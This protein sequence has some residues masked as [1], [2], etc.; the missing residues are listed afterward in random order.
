MFE[1]QRQGTLGHAKP[2]HALLTEAGG[3]EVH[4]R[5]IQRHWKRMGFGWLRTKNR[6]RSLREQA[7]VRQHRHDDLYA[8]RRTRHRPPDER[9]QVIY[10]AESFLP[11]HHGGP[12]AWC[13]DN[14]FV[15][16]RSGK[17]RRWGFMHAMQKTGVLTGTFLAFEAQHGNGDDHAQ[18]DGAMFQHWFTAQFLR[19]V[20]PHSLMILD[21]CPCHTGGRD[22]VVPSQ[23]KKGAL[24][25]WLT[26]RGVAWEEQWL[27]ARRLAERDRERE[28]KPMVAILAAAQGHK[29]LFLPGHHPE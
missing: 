29:V 12:Y 7:E 26:E 20:P 13:S 14:D 11:H 2:V 27:R 4:E 15:E 17:G 23:M 16:R 10:V 8:L 28:K 6:P 22:A 5:T 3:L 9:Y 21:R 25:P 19:H 1:K 18:G 24:R